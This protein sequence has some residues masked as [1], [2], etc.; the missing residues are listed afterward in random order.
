MTIELLGPEQIDKQ[1]Q[2]ATRAQLGELIVLK[3]VDSTNDYLLRLASSLRD[4]KVIACFAEQQTAGKGQRGK[5]W[6]SPPNGQIYCSL[7]WQIS[8]LSHATMGLSLAIGIA[9][10]RTLR[11]YGVGQGLAIKWPNDVY[12]HGQKLVGI[13]VETAPGA[14]RGCNVVCGIGI[15]LYPNPEQAAVIDQPWTSLYQILQQKIARNR[16]AGMLLNE[17]LLVMEQFSNQ[18]LASFQEEWSTWDFLYG[19]QITVTSPQQ[20]LSGIMQGISA[21]GELL[22]LD[23]QQQIHTCLNGTVRLFLPRTIFDT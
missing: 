13:L 8:Q 19:K 3:T 18:G 2:P 20:T 22:L 23:S 21:K 4:E 15:N 6:V 7:L 17:L 11:S 14:A 1:L 12:Y 16:L 5:R 10:A 9:V